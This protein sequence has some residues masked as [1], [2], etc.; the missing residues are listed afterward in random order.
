MLIRNATLPDGRQR[1]V[2]VRGETI[3]EVG[4]DLSP[5][6]EAVVEAT[7][8]RLFP[9]T[10]TP[11]C[12]DRRGERRVTVCSITPPCLH[13]GMVKCENCDEIF[14]HAHELDHEEVDELE[15]DESGAGP[16]R[17]TIGTGLHDVWRCKGC[18]KVLGVR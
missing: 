1:A 4:R 5:A 16:P 15:L 3:A 18:G 12:C 2:R 8:K 9:G 6:D 13:V 17:V 14:E 11:N 10:P 7:G